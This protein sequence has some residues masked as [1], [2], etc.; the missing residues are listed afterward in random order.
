MKLAICVG[1]REKNVKLKEAG[2]EI[3]ETPDQFD[4]KDIDILFNTSLKLLEKDALIV[5]VFRGSSYV[6][7]E[8]LSLRLKTTMFDCKKLLTTCFSVAELMCDLEMLPCR[9]A[10]IVLD[11][12]NTDVEFRIAKNCSA[13]ISC[14]FSGKKE[15]D[16]CFSKKFASIIASKALEE[17]ALKKGFCFRR[18][19]QQKAAPNF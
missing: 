9:E 12:D 3:L 10:V 14:I 11:C 5:F 6:I 16:A 18:L 7:R 13:N 8:N 2:F 4:C 17:T 15:R 19:S 1:E